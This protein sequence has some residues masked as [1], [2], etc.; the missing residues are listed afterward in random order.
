M[1]RG[2]AAADGA[3]GLR[4]LRRRCCSTSC[5]WRAAPAEEL[6]RARRRRGPASTCRRPWRRAAASSSHRATSATGRSRAWPRRSLVGPFAVVARP[7]DNPALDR[8]L[9]APHLDRQHRHL[10]EEGAR[11]DPQTILREGGVV[12]DPDRPERAGEGRHL[13]GASSAGPPAPR[14]WRR[15]SPSRPA[16]L[17]VPGTLR[18]ARRRALPDGLRAARSSGRARGR[19]DE[20]IAALTQQLDV[21]H[22]GLGARVARAVAVAAPALEDPAPGLSRG[23]G[24]LG[25]SRPGPRA[26]RRTA[27]PVS[28]PER[29]LVRAPNWVG[30]VVLSLP[31]LRDL[32]RD[33]PDARL[34]V[35]AR[36][37]VAELYRAVPEV[38]AVRESRGVPRGHRRRCAGA[39]TVAVLLPNSFAQR[40]QPCGAP[41]SPSAGATPPTARGLAAHAPLPGAR[42]RPGPQ[43]GVL[44]S[45]DA[46]GPRA[47]GR[48]PA[49]RLARAAPTEW[50]GAA[51]ALLGADGP[52]IGVN[53]GAFYG[54]AK[55]WLP[56]R[57]AAAAELVRAPAPARRSPS[58][59]GPP[60]GPLGEAIAAQLERAG[61]R[62]LCGETTLAEL[63]GRAL[64]PAAAR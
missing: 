32:R 21:D 26:P 41:A 1:G 7:L 27:A 62:V 5:G 54:T 36:P 52:W 59:R 2:T 34:E 39:S 22:R 58:W 25:S 61:A 50:A 64:A 40:L 12:G 35:L 16:A 13:R 14:R 46:R 19:R 44:L 8:R 4:P 45:G 56:E 48:G 17:I 49:R 28:D 20:D 31:A 23:S 29:L 15:R 43:P 10:Q 57:F 30:D 53:P 63:V 47:R 42:R 55:R 11:P 9:W 38:D 60:S 18:A 3:R 37:W 6:L 51:Q 33:F 24:G